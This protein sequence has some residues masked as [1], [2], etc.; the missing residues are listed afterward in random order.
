MASTKPVEWVAALIT[1][2]G[3][4]AVITSQG[5]IFFN[6]LNHIGT[7]LSIK[8]SFFSTICCHVNKSCRSNEEAFSP[9]PTVQLLSKSQS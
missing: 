8:Y 1:R 7:F 9:G 6:I 4:R 2:W 5:C 3:N